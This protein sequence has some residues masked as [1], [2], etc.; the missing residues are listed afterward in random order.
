M[1]DCLKDVPELFETVLGESLVSRTES[2]PSFRLGP[3]D[4]CHIVK[5][6]TK[7]PVKDVTSYHYVSGI[8]A[9]SPGSLAAYINTLT[10]S[11]D[12]PKGWFSNSG[13]YK[14][15]SGSY[16]CYNAISKV[17]VRVECRFPGGVDCYAVNRAGKRIDIANVTPSF[18]NELFVSAVLRAILNDAEFPPSPVGLK[19]EDPIPNV[20]IENKFIDAVV[21]VFQDGVQLGADRDV[22]VP[23]VANNLLVTGLI[24]YFG[25][26]TGRWDVLVKICQKLSEKDIEVSALLAQAYI[27]LG[28][29]SKAVQTM[30]SALQNHPMNTSVLLCQI[31]FLRQN[32]KKNLALELAKRVVNTS[33]LEF[34]S[35][36]KLTECYMDSGDWEMALLTLNSCPM[37]NSPYKDAHVMPVPAR[38]HFPYYSD[39][40]RMKYVE[41]DAATIT[42]LRSSTLRPDSTFKRAYDLLAA[43]VNKAGWEELLQ[44]RAKVF[45]MEDEYRQVKKSEE[46]LTD[47]ADVNG[48]GNGNAA[49]E[50]KEN[51][52]GS[53]VGSEHPSDP[54]SATNPDSAATSPLTSPSKTKVPSN[55]KSKPA[56]Q[57]HHQSKSKLLSA[58]SH[59]RLCERWLDDLFLILYEDL[60]VYTTWKSEEA[61]A[62]SYSLAYK[63]SPG[64][65]EYLGDLA[66]R[67][68]KKDDAQH[69]YSQSLELAF[70]IKP[71]LRLLELLTQNSSSF[72]SSA[73][74]S[75]KSNL[76]GNTGGTNRMGTGQIEPVLTLANKLVGL[77]S[78]G[79]NG[80]SWTVFWRVY[81]DVVYPSPIAIS[82]FR[83]IRLHG[84]SKIQA[85]LLNL[86]I[87]GTNFKILT[88]WFEYVETFRVGG[89]DR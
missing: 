79:Y 53:G 84:L 26:D 20:T 21:D 56:Q 37:F 36:A 52:N 43:M 1:V 86:S 59:K 69:A 60:R 51:E 32:N 85:S 55:I 39:N 67:L 78:E 77:T 17:D 34:R 80:N 82:L 61:H 23:S 15:K 8:D 27:G 11:I 68:G 88:R 45:V 40:D 7:P 49:G 87:P 12:N 81:G 5:T 73:F 48:S 57:S 63:H 83:L 25:E 58:F 47:N 24:K 19:R 74:A 66:H 89:W 75:S 54:N 46:M 42:P 31:D 9:S 22:Q 13:A 62:K 76:N 4:L 50:E 72:S 6:T 10:Y 41:N 3:P 65:W 38:S 71:A 29:D 35:W 64:E 14:I 70:T 33:P 18:W 30:Y 2:L 44:H 16:C 28:H